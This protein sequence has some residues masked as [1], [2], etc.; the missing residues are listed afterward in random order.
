MEPA[1]KRQAQCRELIT[2]A[3]ILGLLCIPMLRVSQA[4]SPAP[5]KAKWKIL[6]I[7]SYHAPWE[8]TDNQFNG[9]KEVLKDLEIEYKVL[10]MDAKRRNSSE[11]KTYIGEE[12]KKLI[13][14]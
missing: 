11:W 7:M 14:T 5:A 9:F 1:S 13:D 6:H 12:A 4:A 8:W 2:I 3:L 10:Q